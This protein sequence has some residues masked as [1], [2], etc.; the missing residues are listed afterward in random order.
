LNTKPHS[1]IAHAA[2]HDLL[3]LLQDEAISEIRGAPSMVTRGNKSY[4]YDSYRV[5]TN[6]HKAYIGEDTPALRARLIRILRAEG[7]MDMDRATGSLLNAMAKAGVF[8]PGG[9]V[10]GTH[11]FRLYE[12]GFA[13][14]GFVGNDSQ[15]CV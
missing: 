4:W 15:R 14:V 1:P 8:R 2:Y 10:I 6:V 7:L 9:T 13:A 11:A 5:G 3:R 12:G